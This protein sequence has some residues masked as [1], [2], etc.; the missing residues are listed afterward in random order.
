MSGETADTPARMELVPDRSYYSAG[1][2]AKITARVHDQRYRQ[3]ATATVWL[4]IKDPD[5]SVRDLQMKADIAQAGEYT[6]EFGISKPGLYQLE[7]SASAEAVQPGYAS[8]SFV[9]NEPLHE[10][11]Y[12]GLN[13]EFLEK[14][15]LESGGKF[16][17]HASSDRV[18]RDLVQHREFQTVTVQLDVW[19][20]PAVFLFLI[21]CYGL[22][23]ML[24]RRKG[25]S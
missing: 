2:T 10:F 9:A 11:R 18:V 3:V 19:D 6:A 7:V 20:M 4:K 1:D 12:G 23:W 15:A 13:K 24:R 16:Y 5:G 22:E 8:A 21:A 17:R 25:M 14:V